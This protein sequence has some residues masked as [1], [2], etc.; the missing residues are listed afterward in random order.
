MRIAVVCSDSSG[1]RKLPGAVDPE[2]APPLHSSHL[3]HRSFVVHDVRF[4]N[5][6]VE[7]RWARDR[8]L[9]SEM[10]LRTQIE[11]VAMQR[12]QL[13]PG[14]EV[15]HDY[16]FDEEAAPNEERRVRL[17]DLFA[18]DKDTLIIYS[19]MFSSS[20]ANPCP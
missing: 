14:G 6:S 10:E 18:R 2:I 9:E 13:P 1:E 17:S 4:P 11:A 3:S 20:M 7:Y 19:Y 15:A 12:R 16:A 5:E 8:L